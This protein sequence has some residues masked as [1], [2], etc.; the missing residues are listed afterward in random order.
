MFCYETALK[1][2][3]FAHLMYSYQTVCSLH[4]RSQAL[5]ERERSSTARFLP[6]PAASD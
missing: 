6:L 2:Y 3:Y 5:S 4:D 1:A